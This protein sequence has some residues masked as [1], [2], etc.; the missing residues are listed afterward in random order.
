ML[1]RSQSVSTRDEV[2]QI[3]GSMAAGDDTLRV[4]VEISL[5]TEPEPEPEPDASANGTDGGLPR[6]R[7]EDPN[8][9]LL[10]AAREVSPAGSYLF[11]SVLRL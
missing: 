2:R 4:T 8:V 5:P 7:T 9:L 3:L 1:S 11:G 6:Q 10:N